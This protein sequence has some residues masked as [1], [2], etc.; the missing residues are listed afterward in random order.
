MAHEPRSTCG[1]S[2]E[3]RTTKGLGCGAVFGRA[4]LPTSSWRLKNARRWRYVPE[5]SA[6]YFLMWDDDEY[7]TDQADADAKSFFTMLADAGEA[8]DL[9][10]LSGGDGDGDGATSSAADSLDGLVRLP[11]NVW[12]F[13]G[14]AGGTTSV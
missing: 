10:F 13:C 8:E 9:E 2:G 11:G 7:A 12:V 6:V 1:S 5:A 3:A 4:R 14:P